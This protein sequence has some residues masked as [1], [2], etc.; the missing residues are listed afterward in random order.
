V[1]VCV[2]V[3]ACVCVRVCVRARV[4]AYVCVRPVRV[5]VVR[6]C[7]HSCVCVYVC[8][9]VCACVR[10]CVCAHVHVCVRAS[11]RA[12]TACKGSSQEARSRFWARGGGAQ[13]AGM[14]RLPSEDDGE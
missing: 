2:C 9:C 8:E 6:V 5:Q 1:C 10:A 4:H 7:M 12:R 14:A 3:R 13:G 11:A